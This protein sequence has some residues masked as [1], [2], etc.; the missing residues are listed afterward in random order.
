MNRRATSLSPIDEM[1]THGKTYVEVSPEL[2]DFTLRGSDVAKAFAYRQAMRAYLLLMA[3]YASLNGKPPEG[4]IYFLGHHKCA[5]HWIR[6]FLFHLAPYVQCG[7]A[8]ERGRAFAD[9]TSWRPSP[10][11]VL[12]VN[13]DVQV[14]ESLPASA[15][16]FHLV[17]DPRD[18]LVS[19]YFSRKK[20]H[21]VWSPW[22]REMRA[23]LNEHDMD[24][25]LIYLMDQH[26]YFM[27]MEGWRLGEDE[28]V[29]DVRYEDLLRD[30]FEGFSEILRHL[31]MSV[32]DKILRKVID[33]CSFERLSGGRTRGSEDSGHHYRKGVAGDWVNYMPR[34]GEVYTQFLRRFGSL[35]ENLGYEV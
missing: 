35:M 19:E 26:I 10:T 15:R 14:L 31:R 1:R 17:R 20:S 25:G 34:E 5:T 22:H 30:P 3:P 24:D 29:L 27:Q 28:R 32:S 8:V 4:D 18:A 6:W 7:Y 13:A 16:A 11:M 33:R 12:N 2:S 9:F 21:A 23:Y